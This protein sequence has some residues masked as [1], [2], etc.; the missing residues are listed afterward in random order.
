MKEPAQDKSKD[1]LKVFNYGRDALDKSPEKAERPMFGA[2]PPPA[3]LLPDPSVPPINM[4]LPPASTVPATSA[5]LPMSPPPVTIVT[6]NP[7]ETKPDSDPA[8]QADG[9]RRRGKPKAEPPAQPKV[10]P[11]K[12]PVPEKTGRKIIR[13][14]EM[15]FETDSFDNSV[16]SITKLITGVKGG[17]IAT[18]NS[19]KLPNG[20]MQRLRRRP[21]AAAASSTSSST[22]CAASWPRPAS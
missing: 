12:E 17:F 19:D 21:H 10:E 7:G 16:D 1:G 6:G 20:K 3:G 11:P 22:I 9:G 15:E 13:T 14:G 4:P 18:I 2:G 5:Y 8:K